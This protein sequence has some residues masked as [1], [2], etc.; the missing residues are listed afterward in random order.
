MKTLVIIPAYNEANNILSVVSNLK[1][2][3]PKTDYVVV[4]DCS[5]DETERICRA[6]GLNYINLPSNLGIGG[7]VQTGYLYALNNNYDIAIQMDGDGQHDPEFIPKLIKPIEN[8]EADMVIGSRFVNKDKKG[9]QS[10]FMRRLGSK[11]IHC[12]LKLSCGIKISDSTSGYRAASKKLIQFFSENYAQD[13]PE[14]EAIISSV[15]NGYKVEEVPVC[16]HERQSGKSSINP[17]KSINYMIKV[18]LAILIY[19]LGHRKTA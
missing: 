13:Y 1:K 10:S 4:N 14:P 12:M 18:P 11:L 2:T 7:A 5:K 9:F 6:N 19:R 3:S 8:G 15:M 16:M 17:M